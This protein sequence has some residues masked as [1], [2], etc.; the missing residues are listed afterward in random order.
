MQWKKTIA[1]ATTVGCEWNRLSTRRCKKEPFFFQV[2]TTTMIP[3]NRADSGTT[4]LW[5]LYVPVPVYSTVV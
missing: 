1:E 4:Y 2:S 5:I 3:E